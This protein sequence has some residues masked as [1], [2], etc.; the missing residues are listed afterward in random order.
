[1]S[2]R[3]A[4]DDGRESD[5]KSAAGGGFRRHKVIMCRADVTLAS[6]HRTTA[7]R[8]SNR[9]ERGR[10]GDRAHR[11]EESV[12]CTSFDGTYARRRQLFL[13]ESG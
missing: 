8:A 7:H 2:S 6:S 10:L 5:S 1:M 13:F 12:G 11:T 9:P 4:A 3:A